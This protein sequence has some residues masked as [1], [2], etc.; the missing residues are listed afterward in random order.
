M[1]LYLN[2]VYVINTQQHI[3][4]IEN[5]SICVS[6]TDPYPFRKLFELFEVKFGNVIQIRTQPA[7]HT[8]IHQGAETD[9]SNPSGLMSD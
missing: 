8:P 1:I 7:L 6:T 3:E 4:P 5:V 2:V 9:E